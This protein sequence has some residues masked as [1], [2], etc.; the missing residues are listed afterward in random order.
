MTHEYSLGLD[1][2]CQKFIYRNEA[3]CHYNA[4]QRDAETFFLERVQARKSPFV[5]RKDWRPA[6][7]IASRISSS[8]PYRTLERIDW[9]MPSRTLV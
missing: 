7:D 1:R 9:S 6:I 2:D 8:N 3:V 5:L 4:C